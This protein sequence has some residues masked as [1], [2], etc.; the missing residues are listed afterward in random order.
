MARTRSRR[1]NEYGEFWPGYVDVMS[2]LLLT[3]VFLLSLFMLAQYFVSQES[4]RKDTALGK[5][6]LQIAELTSLLSLEKGKSRGL[7]DE[8]AA[9]QATLAAARAESARLSGLAGL[10]AERAGTAETRVSALTKELEGQKEISSEALARVDLLNQQL[11]A[12]RRQIAALNEALAA[13]EAK[14]KDSQ[15]RITDLGARLN[16]VLA[17]QVQELQRYRSDFFGRLRELLRDRK[18]IRIVGDRFIFQSEVLFPSGQA[19][20]TPEGLAAIDQLASAIVELERQIPKEI[21]W[22]LQVDGHTDQRP[23]ASSAFPSNWELSSA[24]ATSVV[25]YLISRGV[26]PNRLV[27]AGYGEF[28]PLEDGTSEE[29]LRRNRRIELKLT[30]R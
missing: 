15:A 10:D 11:L 22:A 21:S 5:L 14:D 13:A 18:D 26:P 29:V 9:I 8:L 23:I 30:N 27:A 24:R 6:N 16:V 2:T 25:K 19:T 20:M 4:G 28:A 3:F 7:E 1:S 12:L 17:R